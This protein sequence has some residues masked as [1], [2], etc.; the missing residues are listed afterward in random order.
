MIED[1]GTRNVRINSPTSE[2][3]ITTGDDNIVNVTYIYQYEKQPSST[4]GNTFEDIPYI[5]IR[6]FRRQDARLYFGRDV[7]IKKL[8]KRFHYVF[9]QNNSCRVLPILGPSGCGKSSL[10]MAGLL[11]ALEN[12]PPLGETDLQVIVLKPGSHPIEALAGVLER[13]ASEKE[14]SLSLLKKFEDE[15]WMRYKLGKHDGLRRITASYLSNKTHPLVLFVDQWE[16]IYSQYQDESMSREIEM[17]REAFVETLLQASRSSDRR[18]VVLLTLRSDFIGEAQNHDTLNKIIADEALIVPAMDRKE[19]RQAIVEPVKLAGY[20]FDESFVRILI[21]DVRNRDGALPLMQF[22]LLQVWKKLGEESNRRPEDIYAEIGGV[23]GALVGRAQQI[24]DGLINGTEKAVTRRIFLQLLH[25]TDDQK[26]TRRSVPISKLVASGETVEYVKRLI[27]KF[28]SSDARMLTLLNNWEDQTTETLV[29]VTHES[30]FENWKELRGWIDESREDIRFQ[31]RLDEATTNWENNDRQKGSLWRSPDLDRLRTFYERKKKDLSEQSVQ[32]YHRSNR[33]EKRDKFF[34]RLSITGLTV[35]FILTTT[36]S[37]FSTHKVY[38]SERRRIELYSVTARGLSNIDPVVSLTNGLA[39][40]GLN[41]SSPEKFQRNYKDYVTSWDEPLLT[42]AILDRP[43]RTM[44]SAYVW[45]ALYD[46][47]ISTDGET[48]AGY[49]KNRIQLWNKEG[50]LVSEILTEESENIQFVEISSDSKT[51][52]SGNDNGVVS[53]WNLQGDLIQ[54]VVFKHPSSVDDIAVS[55]DNKTIVSSNRRYQG[56]RLRTFPPP[57]SNTYVEPSAVYLKTQDDRTINRLFH[58]YRKSITSVA[59]SADGK[60]IAAGD[61]SGFIR[62][63]NREGDLITDPFKSHSG[64]VSSIAVSSDGK[65][66]VSGGDDNTVRIWNRDGTSVSEPFKGHL[67]RIR[68]VA[69]SPDGKT[70]VSGASDNT[71]R[72]WDRD[73]NYLSEPIEES[74]YAVYSVSLSRNGYILAADENST[75]RLFKIGEYAASQPLRGHSGSV[76]STAVSEDG[77][78]I[79]TGGSDKTVRLW[80]IEGT[81]VGLPFEGH[82]GNVISLDISENGKTIVSGSYDGTVRLWNSD[83]SAIGKPYRHGEKISSVSI[84][85]D[86]ETNVSLNR[87][88]I[89]EIRDKEGNLIG[90]QLGDSLLVLS[91]IELSRDGN[92]IIGGS[93]GGTIRVWNREGDAVG[94]PW[95]GHSDPAF[96]ALSTDGQTVVS[97]SVTRSGTN[98]RPAEQ[99]VKFWNRQGELLSTFEASM[100]DIRSADVTPDGKFLVTGDSDGTIRLWDRA[101]NSVAQPLEGHLSGINVIR[102]SADGQAIVSGSSDGTA[103]LW[104]MDLAREGWLSN[105]CNRLRSYLVARSKVDIVAKEA[106]RTCER[107]ATPVNMNK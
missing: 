37:I 53:I 81:P 71:V 67:Q 61:D 102:V 93:V 88:G 69:V 46:P 2:S 13:A 21:D 96:V 52:I 14:V 79:V 101:G 103:R 70:I 32:F 5:G 78:A 94:E 41:K 99:L 100:G 6:A 24:Y 77:K 3:V 51:V 87:K 55:S 7:L 16:E 50:Y 1:K 19:L 26:M 82:T 49:Y 68:S 12:Q 34:R 35:G 83:G 63:W 22:A 9:R 45:Y 10:V 58:S 25:L 76:L 20:Y 56:T 40:I 95:R 47:V 107:N 48:I 60:T 86:G 11:P 74:P 36:L 106:K 91:S 90:R 57:L 4:A 65:T 80:D 105:T 75:V 42:T 43:G 84:S 59:I 33:A 17:E 28:A 27:D 38:Q 62:I 104:P 23:G 30:L 92:T 31:R 39:A 73:G 98:S 8:L 72:I 64:E 85:A 97:Y 15:I 18:I 54:R 66:I 89:A 29:E 44:R